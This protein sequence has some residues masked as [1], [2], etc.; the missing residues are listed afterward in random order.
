MIPII[1]GWW[2]PVED[3]LVRWFIM[4]REHFLNINSLAKQK[5]PLI[6]RKVNDNEKNMATSSMATVYHRTV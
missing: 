3:D 4:T 5:D 1:I 2:D 6:S